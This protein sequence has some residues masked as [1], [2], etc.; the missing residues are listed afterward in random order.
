[1]STRS[2]EDLG[3]HEDGVAPYTRATLQ[4]RVERLD[5]R[6]ELPMAVLGLVWVAALVAECVT[7]VPRW[8]EYVT[9]VIWGVFFIEFAVRFAVAPDKLA[10]LR[11]NWLALVSIVL[12]A[13]PALRA[14]RA[15]QSLR[16]VRLVAAI[17]RIKTDLADLL[18]QHGLRYVLLL[19][20]VVTFAGAA[21]MY[22]VEHGTRDSGFRSYADALWWTA[23]LITTIGS[24]H[25]PSTGEG[26]ILALL[27]SGYALGVLG[28]ITAALSAFLIGRDPLNANAEVPRSRSIDAL[29]AE[30]VE[31]T[32]QVEQLV[33]THAS[34]PP[35]TGE[36]EARDSGERRA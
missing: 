13:L 23:M 7:Q 35:G 14:L 19:T 8:V 16:A 32:R 1:M 17:G 30:V 25:W 12:P 5:A 28:Y 24:Q 3:A 33:R 18:R 29:R 15:L 11:A 6:L 4:T 20:V 21:A 27:L 2:G 31:L 22:A 36:P 10:F 34:S 9:V 26:R